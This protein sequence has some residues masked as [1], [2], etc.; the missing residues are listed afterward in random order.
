MRV[1]GVVMVAEILLLGLLPL[2]LILAAGWD[3]TCYIIPNTL[4]LLICGTFVVFAFATGM[5]LATVGWHA[6]AAGAA[7]LVAMALFALRFIGGGDAKLFA[8]VAFWLGFG[9]LLLYTLVA[10]VIGGGLT[11]AILFFRQLP[12]PDFACRQGWILRLHD[13]KAGI[14]YGV[15]LSCG[16][17]ILL[18]QVDVFIGMGR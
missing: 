6:L 13:S 10:S 8:A 4:S 3:L 2:L 1:P 5:P 11:L 17:L 15:A 7:L 18:P 12:L 9:D 14:P 16:F